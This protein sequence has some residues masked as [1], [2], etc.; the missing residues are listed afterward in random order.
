M[1]LEKVNMSKLEKGVKEIQKI[2]LNS[3]ET[4]LSEDVDKFKKYIDERKAIPEKTYEILLE[5]N[6]WTYYD[7]H[8][9]HVKKYLSKKDQE[10]G[11]IKVNEMITKRI[12]Q[13][14][15]YEPQSPKKD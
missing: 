9:G 8:I 10:K 2:A 12:S 7:M 14:R 5:S 1:T 11:K 15:S 4:G 13:I 6:A 3:V